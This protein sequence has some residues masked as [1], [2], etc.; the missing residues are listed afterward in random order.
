[1]SYLYTPE[2]LVEVFLVS[3][4]AHSSTNKFL[5]MGKLLREDGH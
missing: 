2:Y 5:I 3:R 1:M 4:R